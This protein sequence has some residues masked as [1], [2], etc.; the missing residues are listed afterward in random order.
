MRIQHAIL[1]ICVALGSW[2][3]LGCSHLTREEEDRS[4]LLLRMGVSQMEAGDFP[5][6][7]R[8]MLEAE[9]LNPDDAVIQNNLG[10][11]FFYRD[12]LDMA[13][14]HLRLAVTKSP[15]YTEAANNLGRILSERGK[16]TEAIAL[17]RKAQTDLTYAK[18]AKIS[19]NLGIALFRHR[20][21]EEAR[22]QFRKTLEY[23]RD[24]CLAQSYLG[25]TYFET[26]DYKNA[27]ETLD[28]AVS[29]CKASQFDEP[30]YYS[31]LAF[32][33]LGQKEQA[34]SRLEEVSKIYSQGKYT[35]QAKTMLETIRR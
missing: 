32:Y 3:T 7:L 22:E 33:Q 11:A 2:G 6:A 30:H 9:K 29:F 13:E 17:L 15:E 31:A 20:Q 23:G 5:N 18:P 28:R 21:F 35:E 8:T 34:E 4:R 16:N 12:R 25:R 26:K 19:V 24:N 10:L 27:A 14:K 1:A